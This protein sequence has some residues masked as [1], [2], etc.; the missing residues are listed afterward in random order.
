[1]MTVLFGSILSLSEDI[2]QS[3][4]KLESKLKETK[5]KLNEA[6]DRLT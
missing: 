2:R 1:M 5:I 6:V 4:N 3:K